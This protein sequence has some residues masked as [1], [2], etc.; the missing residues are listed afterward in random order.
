MRRAG[1]G[2]P[3]RYRRPVIVRV[4]ARFV[5]VDNCSATIEHGSFLP[6]MIAERFQIPDLGLGI[7]DDIP[8]YRFRTMKGRSSTTDKTVAPWKSH[9]MPEWRRQKTESGTTALES[10]ASRSSTANRIKL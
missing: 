7:L 1:T 4:D 8:G 10:P 9:Q 5:G 2:A 3:R 6:G